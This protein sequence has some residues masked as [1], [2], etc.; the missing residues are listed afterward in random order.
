MHLTNKLCK[1]NLIKL[2]EKFNKPQK[3]YKNRKL[4]KKQL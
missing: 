2:K 1:L 3:I 4:K